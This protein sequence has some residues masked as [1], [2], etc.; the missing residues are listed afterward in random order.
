MQCFDWDETKAKTNRSQHGIDFEEAIQ[1]FRDEYLLLE[2]DGYV[3]REARWQAIGIIDRAVVVVV[4][5]S[6]EEIGIDEVVRII[7]A[8]YAETYEKRRYGQNHS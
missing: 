1:V 8:R 3:D 7:S 5:H 6:T 2:F 4:V